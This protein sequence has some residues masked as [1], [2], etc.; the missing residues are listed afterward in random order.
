MQAHDNATTPR[1]RHGPGVILVFPLLLALSA[2]GFQLRG[3]YHVPA[4]LTDVSLQLP[5]GTRSLGTELRLA[6]E[7]KNIGANGGDIQLEVATE[8]LNRQT[9]SVDSRARA[10]EYILVYT[11]E[12]RIN[13]SDGRTIGPLQTLI[14]RRAYQYSTA[15]VVGKNTE[16][17]TLMQELRADAAQQIVRQLAALTVSPAA[18]D[19]VPAPPAAPDAAQP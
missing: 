10:A 13:S 3:N 4:F 11:V 14:L 18:P 6:L 5:P 2:C 7:R 19:P 8:T 12:F 16:E 17:E 9:S 15:N 1:R